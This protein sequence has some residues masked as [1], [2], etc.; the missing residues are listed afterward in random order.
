[1]GVDVTIHAKGLFGKAP[2]LKDLLHAGMGYGVMDEYYR[3]Q[4]GQ[5]GEYT[6]VYDMFHIGRGYEVKIDKKSVCLRLPLPAGKREIENFYRL[7]ER[8][9]EMMKVRQFLRDDAP[10]RLEDIP[11]YIACDAD[12]SLKALESI[13]KKVGEDPCSAMYLFGAMHPIAVGTRELEMIGGS[14]EG[15]DEFFHNMQN[16]DVY[17]AGAKV[18][19]R[20]DGSVFGVYVLTAGVRTILPFRPGLFMNDEVQIDEW[21]VGLVPGEEEG[22]MVEYDKFL[23][24]ADTGAVYDTEHFLITLQEEEMRKEFLQ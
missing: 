11:A 2:A 6:V 21:Y 24:K 3:L 18:Y 5:T 4:E 23:E 13:E 10:A 1:M 17:Y 7:T 12:A 14:L 16:M 9:C 8:I 22:H 20:K 19:R 15:M